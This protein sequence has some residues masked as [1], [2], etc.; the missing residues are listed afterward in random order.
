M[1]QAFY[2][3]TVGA[4]QQMQRLNVYEAPYAKLLRA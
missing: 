4:Q 1:L 3:A 2:S